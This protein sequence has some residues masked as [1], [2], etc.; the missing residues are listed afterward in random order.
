M[1]TDMRI[2]IPYGRELSHIEV[3]QSNLVAVQRAPI[4]PVVS[5]PAAAIRSALE[6]PMGFPALRR[7][8][9][10]DDHV[11]IV[12]DEHLPRLGELLVPV[13]EHISL[14][15][16]VPEAIT[17]LCSPGSTAQPWL[18]SLPEAFEEVRLEVHD[19]SD[20]NHL[21]YLATTRKGRRLY[22]N[23]TLVDANQVIVLTGRGYHPLLGY[24][25][26][27][28]AIY[29]ALSD[30]ATRLEECGPMT[31]AA[32]G[33]SPCRLQREAAEVAWHLG[34]PFLVQVVVGADSEIVHV[35]AGPVE[36]SG[37]GQ[38][39]LDERW[40]VQVDAPADIVLAGMGGDPA[41]HTF[42]DLARAFACAARVVKP[43]GKIVLLSDAQPIL[44]QEAD[45]LRRADE[46]GTVL[47]ALLQ[48]KAPDQQGIFLWAS[49]AQQATLY[50][51]S[52]LSTEIAEEL[53]TVPIQNA[54]EVQRL[55]AGNGFCLILPDAHKTMAVLG[56]SATS[57]ER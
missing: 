46:P 13:L 41:W 15:Q 29:P 23:R 27:E 20:R 43:G 9:T 44:G 39:L 16:V 6:S 10:P 30:S 11:V 26:A 3:D 49:A 40:R 19:P 34:V 5:D 1:I 50:L 47:N 22:L 7:A 42:D 33:P 36:T 21:S 37:E 12:I 8:L 31:M 2:S 17:L 38:R 35:L 56:A 14:A 53:F 52:K 55:V 32:P 18:D 4:A 45:W 28:G 51:M 48:H 54:D 25:G 24:S 57:P